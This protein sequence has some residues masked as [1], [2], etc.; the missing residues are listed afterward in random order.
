MAAD[1]VFFASLARLHPRFGTPH[2]AIGLQ[3]LW[4]IL[5]LL[6][7]TYGGLVDSVV[8]GDWIF[9]GLT[10]AAVIRFRRTHP[11]STRGGGA[12][13]TP[14]YP[15][16]PILFVAAAAYVVAG[17][18]ASNPLRSGMGLL[19]LAAGLPIYRACTRAAK[20]RGAHP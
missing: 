2:L 4:G 10:V 11:V 6:T 13:L 9:F 3:A 20:A 15:V 16:V 18:V 1:G 19:L 17:A 8:F 7:G 14:G 12:F 5:L